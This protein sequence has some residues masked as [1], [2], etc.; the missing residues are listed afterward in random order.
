MQINHE[1]KIKI[2]EDWKISHDKI[3]CE[4][5]KIGECFDSVTGPLF[6]AVWESFNTHTKLISKLLDDD[7]DTLLWYQ[8]DCLMGLTPMTGIVDGERR[9]VKTFDDLLW[10]IGDKDAA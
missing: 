2:L 1:E 3:E 7:F 10:L 9:E 6:N 5:N 8:F 4:L